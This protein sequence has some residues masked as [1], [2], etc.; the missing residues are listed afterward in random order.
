MIKHLR[1]LRINAG[2]ITFENVLRGAKITKILICSEVLAERQGIS[3]SQ[4]S[5]K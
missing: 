5:K 3:D 1:F 2:W 4:S